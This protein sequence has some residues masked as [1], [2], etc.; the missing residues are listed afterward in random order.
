MYTTS[1]T[2][3]L[4]KILELG[5]HIKRIAQSASLMLGD[6]ANKFPKLTQPGE[7]KERVVKMLRSTILLFRSQHCN[8][9]EEVKIGDLRLVILVDWADTGRKGDFFLVCHASPLP[10]LP[11]GPINVEVRV[12]PR[13]H[14]TIKDSSW[15]GEIQAEWARMLPSSNEII[16]STP[17]GELL[18]GSQANFFAVMDGVVW[19][20]GKG[21]LE[22][23]IRRILLDICAD[24]GI[25]VKLVPPK[26]KDLP[27]FQAVLISSSSRLALPVNKIIL[28]K[29]GLPVTSD[30][31]VYVYESS[32]IGNKLASL[33]SERIESCSVEIMG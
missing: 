16:L 7:L 2:V 32:G 21:I 1:R 33:V 5:S 4:T 27:N 31:P 13:R 25:P 20:A 3:S 14:G 26:I 8:E 12:H 17:E 6:K 28:P 18:E 22:G 10:E 23:T 29:P 11:S 15:V 30:D 24:E 9:E 19:T